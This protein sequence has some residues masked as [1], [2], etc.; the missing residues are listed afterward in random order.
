MAAHTSTKEQDSGW[1]RTDER[2]PDLAG[3]QHQETS[4]VWLPLAYGYLRADLLG[5]LTLDIGERILAAS[6]C[7]LGCE[8]AAVFLESD[9]LSETV[10]PAFLDLLEE[11]RRSGAHLV[12][13]GCG[14]MSGMVVPHSCLLNVLALRADVHVC[15]VAL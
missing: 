7:K 4:R 11:C 12:L 8:L 10:P 3:G 9:P 1:L 5:N 6:A 15:E 14:H 13:T 2:R